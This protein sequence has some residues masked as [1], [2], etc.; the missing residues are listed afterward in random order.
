M[1][2]KGRYDPT[3]LLPAEPYQRLRDLS[4]DLSHPYKLATN[5]FDMRA[6]TIIESEGLTAATSTQDTSEGK[7]REA[8]MKVMYLKDDI[9]DFRDSLNIRSNIPRIA[10]TLMEIV[11]ISEL[12]SPGARSL[13]ASSIRG[14]IERCFKF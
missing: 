13:I 8:L 6:L 9:E 1:S 2:H 7:D 4:F 10:K 11:Q 3:F 5:S 14:L 12:V